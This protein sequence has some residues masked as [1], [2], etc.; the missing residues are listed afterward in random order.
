MHSARITPAGMGSEG[1][2]S[3]G[4]TSVTC[5]G[6]DDDEIAECDM[7]NCELADL[8][9]RQGFSVGAARLTLGH[10]LEYQ[11]VPP[12]PENATGNISVPPFQYNASANSTSTTTRETL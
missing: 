4:W 5:Q 8:E 6:L 12:L 10:T 1:D 3:D 2:L 7:V 11:N 9:S